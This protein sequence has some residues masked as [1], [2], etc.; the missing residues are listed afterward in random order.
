MKN[1]GCLNVHH[2][3]PLKQLSRPCNFES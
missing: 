1:D 2:P 3:Y